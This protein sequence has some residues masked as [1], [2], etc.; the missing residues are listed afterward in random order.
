M[1]EA[2]KR[3]YRSTARDKK[4]ADT[5]TRI[6]QS[7]QNLFETEG[8]EQVTIEKIAHSAKVSM[9]TI[10]AL[11]QS[12]RGILRALLDE[13]LPSNQ[14]NALVE[15]SVKESSPQERLG[16]SAKIARHIYDAERAQMSLF[17][18]ATVLAP[19]F[20]ELEKEKELRRHTRQEVTIQAMV[21][22][23][24]LAE[25]LDPAKARDILWALTGRDLYRM[26]VIERGWSSDEYETWLTQQL[27]QALII[28][29]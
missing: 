25:G 3:P 23:N 1:P 14:F 26:F 4:A 21:K 5:K 27:I 29:Y 16:I 24:S 18:G 13:A 15:M 2:K 11:F 22:E 7:A 20:R 9:P 17:R 6:L 12:K 19:E 28:N 8:F 10:Y